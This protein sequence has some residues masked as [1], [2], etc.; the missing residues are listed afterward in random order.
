MNFTKSKFSPG[1]ILMLQILLSSQSH[2]AFEAD[3]VSQEFSIGMVGRAATA[4]SV[5]SGMAG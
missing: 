2:K 1:A 4:L 5:S 3:R